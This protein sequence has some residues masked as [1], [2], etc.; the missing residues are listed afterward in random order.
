MSTKQPSRDRGRDHGRGH[1]AALTGAGAATLTSGGGLAELAARAREAA[2]TGYWARLV[3]LLCAVATA[4]HLPSFARSVWSPDEGYLAT[5]A[6]ML[7]GGGVLY[8]T[9]VDR[10]P[11]LLPWLYEA[12][13]G[14]FGSLSLWP[15]RV[16]AIAAHVAT[17]VFLASIAR[18]RWGGRAGAAAGVFYLFVSIGLSPEDSQAATFEVFMLP[19]TAAAVWFAERRDWAW[20]GA[21]TAAAALTKQTGGAVLFP[22]IWMLWR[23]V[24]RGRADWTDGAARLAFGFGLP[25]AVIALA[26]GPRDFF[27]W[28]VSG[29]SDYA[30]A[31]G[32]WL[33]IVGRLFL[34]TGILAAAALALLVVLAGGLRRGHRREALQAARADSDLWVWLGASWLGVITGFHFF[35]HYYLQLVPPLVLL[36]TGAVARMSGGAR[37]RPVMLYSALAAGVF[38]VLGFVWPNQP[39]KHAQQVATTVT[40]ETTPSETV[41]VWGMHPE[42]Y[43]LSDRRPATRY[44]TA[45]LLT[46]YAGGRGDKGVGVQEAVP[47]S[48]QVFSREMSRRLPEIVVDD[49]GSAPYRPADIAPIRA[50]LKAHYVEVGKDGTAVIYRL[51]DGQQYASYGSNAPRSSPPSPSAGASTAP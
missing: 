43:W 27:F 33:D 16:L 38:C 5:Q 51:R 28:V 21:L 23:A 39:L 25:V 31:D 8:D 15:L 18:K 19:A 30:S 20:A 14:L 46:N 2:R 50:L 3:P 9:V 10:K 26:T 45:G 29:S 32:A 6:R 34:N 48:W 22:V 40:R 41:L 1:F 7:A 49:S 24:R 44:L 13:F 42:M 12:M 37:W 36:G 17:A 35:G 47:N 4:T 11:P